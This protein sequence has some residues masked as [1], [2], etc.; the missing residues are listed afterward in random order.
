VWFAGQS[1]NLTI[2]GTGFVTPA[3]ATATGCPVTTVNVSTT[4]PTSPNLTVAVSNINVAS[5]TA[6]TATVVPTVA[7][8]TGPNLVGG[9]PVYNGATAAT[10]EVIP[11]P[12]AQGGPPPAT[13]A[14]ATPA[15]T[16][17][18]PPNVDVLGTP[19][20][21]CSQASMQCNGKTISVTGSG[22]PTAQNAVVGQT[23]TL[24][25]TPTAATL[26]ALPVPLSFAPNPTQSPLWTVGGANIGE[27]VFG[28]LDANANPTS[29]TAASTVLTNPDLT[30]YWLY[31]ADAPVSYEY[32][33]ESLT[34]SPVI[35]ECSDP[36]TATFN[37]IGP[38]ATITA[39]L[40]LPDATDAWYVSPPECINTQ[41][42]NFGIPDPSCVLAAKQ[43]GI[44]FEATDIANVPASG[45]VFKWI[46]TLNSWV[47]DGTEPTG[48]GVTPNPLVMNPPELDTHD[49]YPATAAA[50]ACKT[51]DAP[52]VGLTNTLLTT[53]SMYFDAQMYLLWSS[54]VDPD[55]IN[56]P[57]GY[58]SWNIKGIAD[59]EA[60]ANPPWSL[61]T[62][63]GPTTQVF[64]P[65]TDDGTATH[66]LPAWNAVANSLPEE[67]GPTCTNTQ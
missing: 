45:G 8:Y 20:I 53:E 24:A 59:Y 29:A 21:V 39:L 35:V 62:N 38:T 57:I 13:P 66:G 36:A 42:L 3:L 37:V 56:V 1:Y 50:P 4:S 51:G 44:A 26:E 15:A 12:P 55:S 10:V 27:R 67:D 31:P 23:I 25:T 28:S 16:S 64:H 19:Q 40:S 60:S 18:P 52:G 65:S 61:D 46:Q 48:A 6:I 43:F 41:Y 58:I 30:T 32:C 9:T 34:V 33:I 7:P 49:P 47:L 5:T 17:A 22:S 54:N 14:L 63:Q 2:T 11:T